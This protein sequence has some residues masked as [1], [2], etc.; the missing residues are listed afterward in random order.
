MRNTQ[1]TCCLGAGRAV[2]ELGS[3]G[4]E[5]S[6][7]WLPTGSPQQR[8]LQWEVTKLISLLRV[9]SFLRLFLDIAI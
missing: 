4:W 8:L 9:S 3:V 7:P 5:P 2:A 6:T 1:G